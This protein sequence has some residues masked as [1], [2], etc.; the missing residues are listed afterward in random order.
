MILR[1]SGS[2]E[3][4]ADDFDDIDPARGGD[5]F[6]DPFDPMYPSNDADVERLRAAAEEKRVMAE[7]SRADEALRLLVC[8]RIRA[9]KLA[10]KLKE[11]G[12]DPESV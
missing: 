1:G 2:S 10:A 6:L 11:L 7:R 5:L 8:E 4:T 12:I 3:S 9:E